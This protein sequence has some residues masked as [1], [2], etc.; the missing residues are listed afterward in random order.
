MYCWSSVLQV[1][2]GIW[3]KLLKWFCY[4]FSYIYKLIWVTRPC[5]LAFFRQN[6]SVLLSIDCHM[7]RVPMPDVIIDD[8]HTRILVPLA[9]VWIKFCLVNSLWIAFN[10]KYQIQINI[11]FFNLFIYFCTRFCR[12]VRF[13][14]IY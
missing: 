6:Y 10:Y 8:W 11:Y 7:A 2:Y 4:L 12:F 13:V 1:T 5:F 3:W 14:F 9:F